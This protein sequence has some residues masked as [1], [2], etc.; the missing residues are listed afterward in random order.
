MLAAKPKRGVANPF[1]DAFREVLPAVHSNDNDLGFVHLLEL[2]Q[3]RQHMDAIDSAVCPEIE[4][5]DLAP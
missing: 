2:P 3:L 1:G 5:R 4:Q